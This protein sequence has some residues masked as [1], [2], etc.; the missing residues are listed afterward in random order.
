M[1]NNLK[2]ISNNMIKRYSDRYDELG[3]DVKTLG[4]GSREQQYQ[5]FNDIL[6]IGLL[7]NNKT[8]LDI[9]CGFGDFYTC[10]KR[11]SINF[12]HYTGVDINP[13]LINEAKSINKFEKDCNF[14]VYNI[15]DFKNLQSV[16]VA[17]LIGVLN[18]NLKNK[19]DNYDYSFKIIKNA[20]DLVTESL[21][22]NL[23]DDNLTP[24]YPKE[25]FVFYH[26][27]IKMT[28]FASTLTNKFKI[29]YSSNP[30]PQ[31][32]FNLILYK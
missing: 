18:L 23:L 26:N 27:D 19:A 28:D 22:I 21:V 10:L 24:E 13:D 20:F 8:L 30:I 25:D 9:G 6:D 15:L 4:W 7:L 11:K 17:F 31:K 14:R 2:N 1:K 29:K 12:D 32:E 16:D 3:Y 5:R